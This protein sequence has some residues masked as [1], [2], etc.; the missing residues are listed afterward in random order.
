MNP[1]TYNNKHNSILITYISQ[2]GITNNAHKFINAFISKVIFKLCFS[3][4]C[5]FH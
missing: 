1:I 3:S 4:F 5:A 2:M